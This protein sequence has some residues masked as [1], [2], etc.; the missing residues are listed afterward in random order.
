MVR[1]WEPACSAVA[2]MPCATVCIAEM[3]AV[4]VF[5]MPMTRPSNRSATWRKAWRNSASTTFSLLTSISEPQ[6][7]AALPA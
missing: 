2:D 4:T 1:A 6:A 7:R 3:D 5:T